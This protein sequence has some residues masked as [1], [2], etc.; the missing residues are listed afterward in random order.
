MPTRVSN[1]AKACKSWGLRIEWSGGV[2]DWKQLMKSKRWVLVEDL[3]NRALFLSDHGCVSVSSRDIPELREN[4]IYYTRYDGIDV[5]GFRIYNYKEKVL[6][7]YIGID[8][9]LDF[10]SVPFLVV[11]NP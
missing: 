4:L 7:E 9:S 8:E 2:K 3:G 5:N 1:A 10:W 6:V 11:P